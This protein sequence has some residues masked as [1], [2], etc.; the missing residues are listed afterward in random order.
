MTEAE[1]QALAIYES[2]VATSAQRPMAFRTMEQLQRETAAWKENNPA[3]MELNRA[4]PDVLLAFLRQSFEWLRAEAHLAKNYT[5]CNTLAEGIQIALSRMPKPLPGELVQH[6]FREYYGE[7]GSMAHMFFP[8][9][10]LILSLARD[11]VTDEI[12]SQLRKLH[13]HLAPSPSGKIEPGTQKFRDE[14]AELIRV[15][16]E[17]QLARNRCERRDHALGMG[18]FARTLPQPRTNCPR[19]EMEQEVTRVDHHPRRG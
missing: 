15:E 7:M 18:G 16:G 4:E 6:L 3:F 5:A 14:I 2:L 10:L 11:Q 17:I 13:L 12:R 9:R 1:K 8:V 19:S